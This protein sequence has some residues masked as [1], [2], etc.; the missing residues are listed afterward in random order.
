MVGREAVSFQTGCQ[1]GRARYCQPL[2]NGIV[3]QAVLLLCV[4]VKLIFGASY[5]YV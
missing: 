1:F 2:W 5:E 4:E 3:G